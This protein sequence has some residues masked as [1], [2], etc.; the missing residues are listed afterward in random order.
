[1]PKQPN[2]TKPYRYMIA[3]MLDDLKVGDNFKPSALHLSILPWFALETE[4]K[5]FIDW[6]CR[7]FSQ[8]PLISAEV[9]AAKLY[10]PRKNVPVHEIEPREAF[11]KLHQLALSWF[12]DVGAR[13]A[14]KD[15]YVGHD[16]VPHI[17][18]RRGIVLNTGERFT[19]D[20]LIL[21]RAKRRE[22]HIRQVVAK[23]KLNGQPAA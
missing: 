22:D 8:C 20:N 16:Y 3:Y 4:E 5:P 6:F 7:Q 14:E 15:P 13:W 12:G 1:M 18:Q 10:G 19:V 11:L 17:S 9:G 2:S 23:V 21:F